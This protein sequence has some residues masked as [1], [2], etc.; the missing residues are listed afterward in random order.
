MT[1]GPLGR[2]TEEERRRKAMIEADRERLEETARQ[3]RRRRLVLIVVAWL[4]VVSPGVV[5]TWFVLTWWVALALRWDSP[6]HHRST[7]G[8]DQ[9]SLSGSAPMGFGR[10]ERGLH[11]GCQ[12]PVE[13]RRGAW[14][15]RSC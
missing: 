7:T 1:E 13:A 4:L 8:K 9:K 2:S 12:P 14:S 11:R 15:G 3:T 6:G 5:F 10:S